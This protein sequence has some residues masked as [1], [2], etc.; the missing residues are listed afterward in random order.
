MSTTFF[1]GTQNEIFFVIFPL[2]TDTQTEYFAFMC[3]ELVCKLQ[4]LDDHDDEKE[5]EE[6]EGKWT[7]DAS[8]RMKTS[9]TF[10]REKNGEM[11]SDANK[12]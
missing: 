10:S 8:A 3:L 12:R 2:Y 11:L 9:R 5:E 1:R 7:R 6:D 4:N